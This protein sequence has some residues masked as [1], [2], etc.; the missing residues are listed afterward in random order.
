MDQAYYDAQ[1][2]EALARGL[3][4]HALPQIHDCA[5]I[6]E[7]KEQVSSDSQAFNFLLMKV[8][9]SQ[10]VEGYPSI[11]SVPQLQVHPYLAP[12]YPPPSLPQDYLFH[13]HYNQYSYGPL[14]TPELGPDLGSPVEY[15]P[16]VG[17]P[18]TV[19]SPPDV[20]HYSRYP[21]PSQPTTPANLLSALS[22]HPYIA[23]IDYF[24]QPQYQRYPGPDQWHASLPAYPSTPPV[25]N[26]PQQAYSFLPPMPHT[27]YDAPS[28]TQTSYFANLHHPTTQALTESL[29]VEE[30]VVKPPAPI[31][32]VS[33]KAKAKQAAQPAAIDRKKSVKR[34]A[35]EVQVACHICSKPFAKLIKRGTVAELD[36]SHS[37][38]FTCTDCT[39]N[40]SSLDLM[41]IGAPAAA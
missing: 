11:L 31:R 9:E 35:R 33:T 24:P 36:L 13:Q 32:R 23:P 21:M 12:D 18:L 6:N 27:P 25:D 28:L 26:Y 34:I 2:E 38:S 17:L 14:E 10:L 19:P 1:P 4:T 29:Y 20:A 30:P 41:A 8:S 22:P 40:E 5:N 3:A 39:I 15:Q 7:H 37:L 16:A